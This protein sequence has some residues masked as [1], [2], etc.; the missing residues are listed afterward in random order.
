VFYPNHP[1]A[2]TR[3]SDKSKKLVTLAGETF[4]VQDFTDHLNNTKLRNV[5]KAPNELIDNQFQAW[6]EKLMLDYE[7]TQLEGKHNDFRLLM[8]EYHDG[9]L[10]FELTDEKV[11][12]RAVKDTAGLEAFHA[13]H[14]NDFMWGRRTAVTIF[15][16][17][18]AKVVK[19]V[20]K[21]IKKDKDLMAFQ[22]QMNME[23]SN[24]LLMES[25]LFSE[26]EN[27]WADRILNDDG[28][29]VIEGTSGAMSAIET[30]EGAGGETILVHVTEI[31]EPQPKTL[32]EARGQVIAAYQDYL[33]AAWIAELRNNANVEVNTDLLHNL[34]D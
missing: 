25:G 16:C 3:S 8:E 17:A 32:M 31:R 1:L 11:W 12:S 2:V 19:S 23:E 20:K 14:R 29:K 10:L 4:T 9:I 13:D 7:D 30:F 24:A 21:A 6:T 22:Q 34:A 26:G 28:A 5:D 18:N 15:T 33:E 27:T